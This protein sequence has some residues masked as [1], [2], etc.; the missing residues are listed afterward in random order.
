MVNDGHNKSGH[1]L[2]IHV[3]GA[4]AVGLLFAAHLRRLGHP[5]TLLL[6]SE[7]LVDRLARN[8]GKVT[9]VNDWARS[10]STQRLLPNSSENTNVHVVSGVKAEVAKPLGDH[11]KDGIIS[12]LILA[13]KAQDTVRAYSTVHHRLNSQ[14]TVVMLQNGMGTYEAILREFYQKLPQDP[15]AHVPGMPTFVIGT[16]SHGCLRKDGEEFVTH[17]TAMAACKFAVRPSPYN[18]TCIPH[19]PAPEII[20]SL[21]A[22]PLSGT[23]VSWS[24]LQLQLLLKL[25]ANAIINPV[26]ALVNSQNKCLVRPL[27]DTSE[28]R[29]MDM[30]I[31]DYVEQLM[32]LACVE[33]SA[34]YACGYPHLR[35]K[36]TADDIKEY[37][38]EVAHATSQN[39]SSMLQDVC[40]GRQTEV[41]WINGHLVQLGQQHS[42]PTPVNTLLQSLVRLKER[43]GDLQA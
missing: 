7:H 40:A 9:I 34:V 19:K 18:S 27:S 29:D 36:L 25:A 28:Q 32:S 1:P 33:I 5:I 30:D 2:S 4:G 43:A 13:I 12:N 35:D 41:D 17:H 26:T 20:D 14:S 42:V 15:Q 21:C 6:R 39:R 16:N 8:D 3:L 38:T 22:L 11:H 23:E 37:V 24:D 31:K 10:H